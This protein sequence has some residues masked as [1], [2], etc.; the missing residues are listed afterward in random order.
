MNILEDLKVILPEERIK[1]RLIDRHSYARDASFY[2]LIPQ[3]IVQPLNEQEITDLFE[4]SRRSKTPLVFRAAGTSLS[5]QAITDGI[6]VEVSRKWQDY[7]FDSE[8]NVIQLEPGLIGGQVNRKLAPLG[9]KIG[10]DPASLD[11][12]MVGG[13]VA[14]NA[15]GMC[16][17]VKDNAYHTLD[18]IRFILPNGQCYDTADG[19]ADQQLKEQAP[20]IHKGLQ[21]LR[22]RLLANTKLH[23]RVREKYTR[24]NTLGYSLNAFVDYEEPIDILAHLL[25]GSEG[26]LGFISKARLRTLP[27]KPFKSAA[28]LFFKDIRSATETVKTLE[29]AG[30]EALELMDRAA[31]HSIEAE[32][33]MPSQIKTLP[34]TAAA[35]LCEFQGVDQNELKDKVQ[36]GEEVLKSA[37]LLHPAK[38]TTNESKRLLYW[39]IRKGLLP[40]VG[41]VRKSGTT[42][43]IEDICFRL[44]NLADATLELQDLFKK[45]GYDDAIIFGHAKDGNLHFVI[46]QEFSGETGVKQYEQFMADVVK[47]TAVKYDG[48]LKAEHGTGRNMAPFLETEWGPEAVAIMRDL[49]ALIDPELLLNPGVIVNDD[50]EIYL[51]NI[52][53]TPTIEDVVDRCIECGFCET[54]CPSQDL[55][56]TPRRRIAAWREIEMLKA[57]DFTEKETAQALLKD[58][59]FESVDTC[60]VDGLCAL[61]CPVKIDTG[62]LTRHFRREKHGLVSK[63]IAWWTVRYFSFVVEM[64]RIGLN[65]ATPLARIIGSERVASLSLKLYRWSGGRIPVW[66]K[67][68]PTGGRG[69]PVIGM[70]NPHENEE[71]VYFTSCLNRGMN[72]TPGETN[73]ISTARAFIELLQEAS[74]HPIYPSH[75]EELCC[76]TPYSSKGFDMAFKLMAENTVRSLWRTSKQGTLPIVVDTSPCTYKMQH[77][78]DVLD[79]DYLKQWKKLKIIDL[80]EY[81]NDTVIPR[82]TIRNKM[83]KIVLHPTCSTRKMGL[84]DKLHAI[85]HSCAEETTIPEEVGCCAFAGDRGFLVPELTE[86][87][88]QREAGEVKELKGVQGHFSSSRT[89]EMGMSAATDETYSSIVHLVH[90]SVFS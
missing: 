3:V 82:L 41:A 54:W 38:F 49:K 8:N 23:D 48:A 14:N 84:D 6:L 87:A 76:G 65:I 46:S 35:L 4:L 28:L 39:K 57:G 12:A 55:T 15:S 30:A 75:L 78:D 22:K 33:G 72:R 83:D 63:R 10:P 26:T 59:A 56:M 13:I 61:G 64:I 1:S 85:G 52:K 79:G 5:G 51:K 32:K 19:D 2:R 18:T 31:L 68:M 11:A 9:R 50:P 34:E 20:D 21:G 27:D 88:T 40:S 73:K 7:E 25:V 62:D 66:H 69:L 36:A 42:V 77:Y 37:R 58:Y 17:G 43:I 67:Y 16:C 44:E 86:S 90:K 60:A 45:H 80:I 89:C 81:L 74:I 71:V 70:K 24:K 29:A 53:Q 47:M